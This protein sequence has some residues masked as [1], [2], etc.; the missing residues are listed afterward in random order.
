MGRARMSLPFREPARNFSRNAV[1]FEKQARTAYA[2]STRPRVQTDSVAGS[3]C[4]RGRKCE[5][6]LAALKV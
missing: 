1:E 4:K 5:L 6:S 3:A 2:A